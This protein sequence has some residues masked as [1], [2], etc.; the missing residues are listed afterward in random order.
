MN[1]SENLWT[2]KRSRYVCYD[3]PEL[4]RVITLIVNLIK[5]KLEKHNT[6]NVHQTVSALMV[7]SLFFSVLKPIVCDRGRIVDVTDGCES[8]SIFINWPRFTEIHRSMKAEVWWQQIFQECASQKPSCADLISPKNQNASLASLDRT[9]YHQCLCPQ[10]RVRNHK[11][12]SL[13][14]LEKD[15]MLLCHN[16]QTFNLEGS[17]VRAQ[18]VTQTP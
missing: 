11:Y 10:D 2:S 12:R 5:Y 1:W 15:V 8:T 16:A 9:V 13:G 17:Q 3:G 4:Q 18:D 7:T 14:D 6:I